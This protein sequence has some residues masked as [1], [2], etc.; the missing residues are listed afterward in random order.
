MDQS[1]IPDSLKRFILLFVPS[2]PYLEALLLLRN[3]AT[4]LWDAATL[5]PQLY[6]S[7]AAAQSL[8][9]ELL[10]NGVLVADDV[11]RGKFRYQ[12]RTAE[13]AQMIDQLAH[14]YSRNLIEITHLIHAKTNKKAYKFANAFI[15][16][17]EK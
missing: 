5:A 8:V 11:A 9:E 15:W 17:K 4:S 2:V 14:F 13:L 1:D 10:K 16:G 7:D 6:L 12:P 3:P